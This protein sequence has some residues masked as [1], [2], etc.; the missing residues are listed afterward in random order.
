MTKNKFKLPLWYCF[1]IFAGAQAEQYNMRDSV[2]KARI[3]YQNLNRIGVKGDRIDSVLGTDNA[4]HWE[5][6]DKTGE[7]FIRPTEENG[8]MPLSLSVT[9]VSG[10]TQ[11][12]LLEPVDGEANSIKLIADEPQ[13]VHSEVFDENYSGDYEELIGN[14]MKKFINISEKQKNIEISGAKDRIYGH[15]QAKFSKAYKIGDFLCMKFVVTTQKDGIFKLHERIF[16]RKGDIA[17]SFS[18][19]FIK[20]NGKVFLYVLRH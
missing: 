4:F 7:I 11:D 14:V 5:K 3:S 9:T 13:F 8:Y 12:L 16:S 18:D 15:L 17:L 10:K 20:K 19:L 2:I 6:N 1:A